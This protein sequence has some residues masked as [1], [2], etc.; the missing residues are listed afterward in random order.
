MKLNKSLLA[1]ALS[2]S[3]AGLSQATTVYMSGSTAA[4][5]VVYKAL[6]NAGTVFQSQPIST[7]YKGSGA[8]ASL[9]AFQGTL[10][11]GGAVTIK[12][13]W[14]GSEGGILDVVSNA[15]VTEAFIGDSALNGLENGSASPASVDNHGVDIGM[16]DNQ[17][18]Y[19]RTKKPTLTTGTDV[20]V[21]TFK[22]VRNPGLW[23]GTNVTDSMIRQA[24]AGACPRAVFSGNAADINDYVYVSGRDNLSGT[25][26]NA[27]GNSGYGI[28][29]FPYQIEIN[30]NTGTMLQVGGEYAGDFG[31]SSGGTLAATLGAGTSDK[32]DDFNSVT[33]YSVIAY[34]GLSDAATAVAAGA[35]EL[36]YNGV[37]F[38]AAAV[39]EGT[40]TFWG[41]EWI[42]KA[43]VPF[44]PEATTVYNLLANQ[45]TGIAAFGNG[46]D[47]IK[48]TDMH[49]TRSN[50]VSDPSHK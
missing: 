3:M 42:Y 22:W 46:S 18:A 5:N 11:G 9:M 23:L 41:N 47:L 28:F 8:K 17:Q 40:Y 36:A 48:K 4:R 6:T 14:S 12:C 35:T 15:V 33:G 43:N 7:L 27:F 2:L 13:F 37:P 1:V 39:K 10:V 31:W 19:S 24:F 32:A 50:P 49:A 25:R 44:T 45:T 20:G 26:A 29:T 30:T 21:I 34:L 16:A 38:S